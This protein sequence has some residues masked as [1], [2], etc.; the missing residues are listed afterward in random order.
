VE[1]DELLKVEKR[2]DKIYA[3][4]NV[5]KKCNYVEADKKIVR[6]VWKIVNGSNNG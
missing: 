6:S 4:N 1:Y 5:D 2:I 3:K